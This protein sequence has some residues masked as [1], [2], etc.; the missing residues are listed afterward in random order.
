MFYVANYSCSQLCLLEC[1]IK[2]Q[3]LSWFIPEPI[4]TYIVNVWKPTSSLMKNVDWPLSNQT[5][6][7][8]VKTFTARDLNER[9]KRDRVRKQFKHVNN[10]WPTG[11]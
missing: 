7:G 5:V 10:L 1:T 9:E 6:V 4:Q 2:Y 11:A 3:H 8:G